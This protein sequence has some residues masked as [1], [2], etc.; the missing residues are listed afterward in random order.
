[1][2]AQRDELRH[3]IGDLLLG[4]GDK[5]AV[6]D[7]ESLF[8]SGRLD[9]FSMTQL[10]MYMEEKLGV[11]FEKIG[12]DVERIDSINAICAMSEDRLAV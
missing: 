8:F 1:M 7:E 3:F 5:S 4:R 11:D 12:F 10:I 6:S 2:P 9:S